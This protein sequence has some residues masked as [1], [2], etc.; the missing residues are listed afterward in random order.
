M[1]SINSKNSCIENF[2]L[3]W[4]DKNIIETSD[5]YQNSIQLF[6]SFVN[7]IKLF[8]NPDEFRQF[9]R[10]IIDEKLFIIISGSFGENLFPEL[11]ILPQIFS[12]YIFCNQ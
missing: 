9:I 6:Q 7:T 5:E 1:A 4:L 12:I 2:I 10:K 3:I 8:S 11:E